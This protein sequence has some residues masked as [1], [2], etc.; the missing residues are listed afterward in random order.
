MEEIYSFLSCRLKQKKLFHFP[1]ELWL[2]LFL[3][4]QN[5]DQSSSISLRNYDQSPSISLRNYDQSPSI[6]LPNYD[7]GVQHFQF[8]GFFL[9]TGGAIKKTELEEKF[10]FMSTFIPQKSDVLL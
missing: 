4:P 10:V 8:E 2:N 6:S 5:Y 3:S 9:L 1:A 7:Q